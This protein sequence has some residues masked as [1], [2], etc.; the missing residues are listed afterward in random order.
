MKRFMK[1]ACLVCI[2]S[3]CAACGG[4]EKCGGLPRKGGASLYGQLDQ[5]WDRDRPSGGSR[6]GY[7]GIL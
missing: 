2:L 1:I 6:I 5:G 4:T 7:G 3:L